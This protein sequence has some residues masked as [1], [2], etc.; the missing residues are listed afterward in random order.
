[1][2]K[3]NEGKVFKKYDLKPRELS[4]QLDKEKR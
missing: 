1:V 3:E 4:D 2:R